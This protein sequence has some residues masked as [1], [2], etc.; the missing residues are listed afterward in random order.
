VVLLFSALFFFD[1]RLIAQLAAMIEKLKERGTIAADVDAGRASL[2]V[3]GICLSWG[4]SFAMND[5]LTTDVM[6]AEITEAI[7]LLM[8]GMLPRR[9]KD[10]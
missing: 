7:R 3:Y 9:E 10:G 2:S 5:H 6:R 8:R 1:T 4:L